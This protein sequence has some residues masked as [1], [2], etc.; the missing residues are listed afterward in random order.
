MLQ[1]IRILISLLLASL[2][3]LLPVVPIANIQAQAPATL[4]PLTETG[5]ATDVTSGGATLNGILLD[6]GST[7]SVRVFFE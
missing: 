3:L 7:A 5:L 4:P 2:I 1:S 6:R